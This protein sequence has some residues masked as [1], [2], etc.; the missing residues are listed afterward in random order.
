MSEPI[1]SLKVL[2]VDDDDDNRLLIRHVLGGAGYDCLEA[3]DA[4]TGKRLLSEL[5]MSVLVT[6]ISLPGMSCLGLLNW[7]RGQSM[8][9]EVV[10]ITA[11][12]HVETAIEALR[13]GA[14]DYLT[15][16]VSN[17]ALLEALD[18]VRQRLHAARQ[19]DEV[20]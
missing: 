1:A 3:P 10:I 7:V 18:R 20:L 15:W 9:C 8:P 14:A 11:Y 2:I 16:P 13:A 17:S 6:D 19:A 12:P 5:P 4:E